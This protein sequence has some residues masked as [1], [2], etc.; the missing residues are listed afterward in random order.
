M[1][2]TCLRQKKKTS[3][4]FCNKS[5]SHSSRISL[6]MSPQHHQHPNENLAGEP[7]HPSHSF[8]L[9]IRL[10]FEEWNQRHENFRPLCA[11]IFMQAAR[12]SP[13]GSRL[14]F[15]SLEEPRNSRRVVVCSVRLQPGLELM[16]VML[17]LSWEALCLL[18]IKCQKN[19]KKKKNNCWQVG[20][21]ESQKASKGMWFL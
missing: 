13:Q 18:R 9:K 19:P 17:M 15:R 6:Q 8:Y 7:E 21:L 2:C 11:Q 1:F 16:C 20:G 4:G 5:P 14:R 3:W 12:S 10:V